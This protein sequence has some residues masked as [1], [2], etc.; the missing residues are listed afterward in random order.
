MKFNKMVKGA[1]I[2][3]LSTGILA[4]CSGEEAAGGLTETDLEGYVNE[5]DVGTWFEEQGYIAEEDVGAWFEEQGYLSEDDVNLWAEEQGLLDGAVT[6][7]TEEVVEGEEAEEIDYG[8]I[9]P[10]E[11]ETTYLTPLGWTAVEFN[12]YVVAE[13]D[14]AVA[15]F[16]DF[17]ELEETVGTVEEIQA[18]EGE[19]EA[20]AEE[21]DFGAI[22]EA[23][24]ETTYLTPLGWTAVEFNDYVVAE[25]DMAIAD[26]SD[27]AELEETVGTVEEIEAAE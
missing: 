10:V 21:V 22:D 8:V 3:V 26:F 18:A 27:F 6:T 1:G 19:E 20:T 17:A 23:E 12:D 13:Y 24:L 9:D 11:L 25:Y 5:D 16:S 14:M 2:A 4:A 15:D 7:E